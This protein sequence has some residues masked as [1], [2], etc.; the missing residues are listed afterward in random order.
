MGWYVQVKTP[1]GWVCE[2]DTYESEH[3]ADARGRETGLPYSVER[4][5]DEEEPEATVDVLIRLPYDAA[6][7]LASMARE[8]ETLDEAVRRW[9]L[10]LRY[11]DRYDPVYRVTG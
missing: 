3:D 11:A 9:L 4:S 7:D 10:A 1:G 8:G 2:S 6:G 5:D